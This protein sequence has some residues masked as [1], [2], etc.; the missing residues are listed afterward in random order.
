MNS[1]GFVSSLHLSWFPHFRLYSVECR[2]S[3]M[4]TSIHMQITLPACDVVHSGRQVP[5][6][7]KNLIPPS[8]KVPESVLPWRWKQYV[9]P[10]H[11]YLSTKLHCI[12][13]HK[14]V[15]FVL[16]SVKASRFFHMASNSPYI[17]TTVVQQ[18]LLQL[19]CP[20]KH[21]L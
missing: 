8:L 14:T 7:Q 9:L 2:N 15:I 20:T 1:S 12:I 3:T 21:M 17:Q 19:Q 5:M 4:P 16:T 18:F 10:T 11:W 13:S 6:F